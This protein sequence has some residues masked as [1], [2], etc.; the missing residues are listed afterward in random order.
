[1]SVPL[2]TDRQRG[3][4]DSI[5]EEIEKLLDENNHLIQSIKDLHS[6]GKT[7]ECLQYMKMLK[8]NQVYL[9][10]CV[11]CLAEPDQDVQSL[12]PAILKGQRKSARFPDPEQQENEPPHG[13]AIPSE[14]M[15]SG[16]PPAPHMQ[17]QMN[18][19]MPGP[20]QSA[21]VPQQ[22]PNDPQGQGHW[23]QYWVYCPPQ[24]APP[25]GRQQ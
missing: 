10:W 11:S 16:G 23:Q 9:V 14:G 15:V 19:Q 13:Q 18:G 12:L 2:T 17:S 20:S 25:Q 24:T 4:E 3:K 8:K 1:M 5:N 22:Y 21:P 7:A 6:K